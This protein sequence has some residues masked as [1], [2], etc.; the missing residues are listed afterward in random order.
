M[1]SVRNLTKVYKTKGGVETKALD[2][3]TLDFPSTG[4]IFL[5]G[6]SGSGKSTLL[7]VIGGLDKPTSGEIIIK[8]KNSKDFTSSDFDSYRNTYIGFVFQEYNILNEFNVEQNIS[9]ALQL[10]GKKQSKELIEK[11]LEEVDLKGFNKRKPN[12]LSGGQKQRIAIARA[13]IKNPEIIMADEPTGALDSSTG[14]QVLETLKKLSKNKLVIVVSHDKDFAERFADRII[15]LADGKVISDVTK[16]KVEPK[17]LSKNIKLV[18]DNVLT[19]NNIK[20][21][22]EEEKE[23]LF[24]EFKSSEGEIIITRGSLTNNKVKEVTHIKNDDTSEVFEAT[25]HVELNEYNKEDVKFIKSKLPFSRA[26]KMGASSLKVKAIRLVATIFLTTVSL[27][28]FGSLSSLMFY[29]EAYSVSEALKTSTQRYEVLH[30]NKTGTVVNKTID[31]ESNEVIKES[32]YDNYINT[33]FGDTE[34][35][36]MREQSGQPFNGIF[37]FVENRNDSDDI[38]PLYT[39]SIEEIDKTNIPYY[40]ETDLIGFTDASQDA[41]KAQNISLVAGEAPKD[42]TEIALSNYI[43]E[44]FIKGAKNGSSYSLNDLIGKTITYKNRYNFRES[45]KLKISGFYKVENFDSKYDIMKIPEEFAN[46]YYSEQNELL[47]SFRDELMNSYY[48]VGFVNEEFYNFYKKPNIVYSNTQIE[49]YKLNAVAIRDFIPNFEVSGSSNNISTDRLYEQFPE[50]YSFYNLKGERIEYKKPNKDELYLSYNN[51]IDIKNSDFRDYL[52]TFTNYIFPK[53]YLDK[54]FC[55]AYSTKEDVEALEKEFGDYYTLEYDDLSNKAKEFI[56]TYALDIK[57]HSLIVE[58]F[59]RMNT[60][61]ND[62]VFVPEEKFTNYLEAFNKQEVLPDSYYNEA[63]SYARSFKEAYELTLKD[64]FINS[65]YKILNSINRQYEIYDEVYLILESEDN[66]IS[67]KNLNRLI[68]IATSINNDE[69]KYSLSIYNDT[70]MDTDLKHIKYLENISPI[71]YATAKNKSVKLNNIGYYGSSEIYR[72]DLGDYFIN[73]DFSKEIGFLEIPRFYNTSDFV[74]TYE[75]LK[76]AKYNYAITNANYSRDSVAFYLKDFGSHF[77]EMTNPMYKHVKSSVYLIDNLKFIFSIVGAIVGAFAALMFLNFISTSISYKKK[78][79]GILRAVGAKG[80]D[81]FKIFYSETGIITLICIVLSVIATG[82]TCFYLNQSLT[83][84]AE[85]KIFE[86]GITNI[87]SIIFVA[88]VIS[89]VATY[90][91]ILQASKKAPVD[92]IRS[93]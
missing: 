10:Q 19:I 4:M 79:I 70:F 33:L 44:A 35:K 37:T 66:E 81:V 22:S 47:N 32:S 69:T 23:L 20:N 63:L 39:Y 89:L 11:Y 38:E 92:S 49:P 34:I 40:Q 90:I 12:T 5:L 72:Y 31:N 42:K 21:L 57:N 16:E 45:Y 76:D 60:I 86:F 62:T 55:E 75:E 8:G 65:Y 18:N 74:T 54:E 29:N 43:G 28:M 73:H 1:L 85:I 25:T 13:L 6:K 82:L 68:E 56:E 7:N 9:L 50:F 30:K 36:E 87:A 71:Y 93:L 27:T 67:D 77:Y 2:N 48:L 88:L 3:I 17:F 14:E 59:Q 26:F 15:E 64:R 91:P 52:S 46:L 61:K 51:F 78:E 80:T 83:P 58:I 41:L 53:A 84:L 24:N